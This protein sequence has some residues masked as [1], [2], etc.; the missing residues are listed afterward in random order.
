V[1][2]K[3]ALGAHLSPRDEK[4]VRRT[5]SGLLKIILPDGGKDLSL[6]LKDGRPVKEQLKKLAALVCGTTAYFLP[7]A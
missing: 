4:A 7:R 5:V 2:A 6:P 3:F 1:S